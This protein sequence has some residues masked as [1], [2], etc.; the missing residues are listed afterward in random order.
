MFYDF[1]SQIFQAGFLPAWASGQVNSIARIKMSDNVYKVPSCI[2]H[3]EFLIN[4]KFFPPSP[5]QIY[6]ES[7]NCSTCNIWIQFNSSRLCLNSHFL[8]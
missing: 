2:K 1:C 8:K 6:F 7:C 4:V 5:F 3:C